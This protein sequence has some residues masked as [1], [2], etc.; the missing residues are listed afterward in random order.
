LP[1]AAR[2]LG[3]AGDASGT[4][5]IFAHNKL[6]IMVG[7][8]NPKKMPRQLWVHS[9]E[10]AVNV[11]PGTVTAAITDA[12]RERLGLKDGDQVTVVIKAT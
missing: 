3:A 11:D 8:G 10:I 12:S 4:P 7:A 5:K 6:E 1:A 9:T 2:F